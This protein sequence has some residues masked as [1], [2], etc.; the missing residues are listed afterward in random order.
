V[1]V[2]NNTFINW[3]ELHN[4][5]TPPPPD[6]DGDPFPG[7][8]W[9]PTMGVYAGANK[10]WVSEPGL[11]DQQY[12]DYVGTAN[13]AEYLDLDA[14]N[15]R[16]W[17]CG[18]RKFT[19]ADVL[20]NQSQAPTSRAQAQD[21]NW[22]N[23]KWNQNDYI[24]PMLDNSSAVA[25]NKAKMCL[26]V[27]VSATSVTDPVPTWMEQDP[28]KL[29]WTDGQ[30]KVHVRFDKTK[31]VNHTADFLIALAKKYGNDTRIDSL[32]I[33]EYYTNPDG[34]GL[35]ADL[36]YAAFRSNMKQVWS[37]VIAAAPRDANGERM[38]IAQTEPIVSG[39]YV[40]AQDIANIGIGISGSGAQLFSFDRGALDPIRLQLYG[41][42]PMQ[43][44]VNSGTISDRVT[45][46][47][48]PNPWGFTAGQTVP[49]RYEYIA[50]HF[51]SKGP[52]PLDSLMMRD[53]SNFI[54]QWHEAYQKFGPNGSLVAQWGQIPNYP[55]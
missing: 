53:D 2:S 4:T 50:W 40:T 22:S 24:D 7:I 1:T 33:G 28:D 44:Q 39:G 48:T 55:A 49:G 51:G 45:W 3:F 19:W 38:T 18:G 32:T 27:A 31:A 16:Y 52:I 12:A 11:I 14:D 25:A 42:V 37:Q 17:F 29:T 23:Y 5:G 35:P 46:D 10:G 47:G 34:G 26:F 43:H 36:D 21:P 9:F 6:A 20:V 8:R 54:S 41:V 13:E 15:E 30:G